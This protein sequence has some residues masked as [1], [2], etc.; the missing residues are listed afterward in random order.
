MWGGFR[1]CVL[2]LVTG[3]DERFAACSVFL[4]SGL[5]NLMVEGS[6]VKFRGTS[7][8]RKLDRA[9]KKGKRR[10]KIFSVFASLSIVVLFLALTPPS[11]L[12]LPK[13]LY[14]DVVVYVTF[15]YL[16]ST[17]EFKDIQTSVE[18]LRWQEKTF[19]RLKP[20]ATVPD[21]FERL[22][23]SVGISI[24]L[25]GASVSRRVDVQKSDLPVVVSESFKIS[26]VKN[27]QYSLLLT[28]LP[29][30]RHSSQQKDVT[31]RSFPIILE[32]K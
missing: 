9:R 25:G 32:P 23:N 14:S 30:L 18:A 8:S 1:G 6:S 28:L 12:G 17:D 4:R 7:M 2:V 22:F 24:S 16:Y 26:D 20:Y 5:L 11:V 10:V 31:F 29:T 3:Y 13:S 15:S 19:L 27:G 21:Q